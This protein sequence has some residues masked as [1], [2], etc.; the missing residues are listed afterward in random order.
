MKEDMINASAALP[1]VRTAVMN[2]YNIC[3]L[4]FVQARRRKNLG[5]LVVITPF[6]ICTCISTDTENNMNLGVETSMSVL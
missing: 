2:Q 5:K 6:Q 3:T 1:R 4:T